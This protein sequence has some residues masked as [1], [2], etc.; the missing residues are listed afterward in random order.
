MS[1]E[2]PIASAPKRKAKRKRKPKKTQLRSTTPAAEKDL[3]Q[4]PPEYVEAIAR[5]LGLRFVL[6]VC[7][8][9]NTRKAPVYYAAEPSN[10]VRQVG[11][12]ALARDWHADVVRFSSL[13]S[14]T[15]ARDLIAAAFMNPPFSRFLPFT[16]KAAQ[17]AQKG[18]PV[19]GLVK[20]DRSTE[21]WR[22]N[23]RDKAAYIIEPFGRIQY[24][25][26]DGR[27]FTRLDKKTGKEEPTSADFYSVFVVWMPWIPPGG[28]TTLILGQV[29]KDAAQLAA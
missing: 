2:N 19:V 15:S 22:E 12:D 23:V 16:A 24:L 18:L 29:A 1:T 9:A 21:W 4:T 25:R 10:D 3:A 5:L 28:P 6:D 17:E 14:A 27:R 7:A 26:P 8:G 20:N 11:V 13:Y